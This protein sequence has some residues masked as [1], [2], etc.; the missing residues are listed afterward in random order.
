[1][2]ASIFR[3]KE[4]LTHNT[5][6]FYRAALAQVVTRYVVLIIIV[7]G[8]VIR[9]PLV[10]MPLTYSLGDTWRQTDTASIAH[11]FAG[12]DSSI[13]YPRIHWGGSGPGYVEAEFQ[14]Y[15]YITSL[16]YRV[17]GEQVALGRFVSLL[18]TLATF[19]IFHKLA[20]RL[21]SKASAHWALFAFAIMPLSIRY[22]TAFMPEATVLFF[23]VTALYCFHVWLDEQKLRLLLLAGGSTALAFL[24]KPT[25]INIGL[26]FA[27]LLVVRYR[28][29]FVLQ[30]QLW[31]F[32]AI[33][34]LP[35]V[36]WYLH[37]RNLFVLYGNTFGILSGGDSK[38][39]SLRYWLSPD[40]YASLFRIE[41]QWVFAGA[42]LLLFMIGL[43]LALR[44]RQPLLFLFG[45]IVV[46][47]YYLIVARYAGFDRG[48]QYHIYAIPFAA[49][50]IGAGLARLFEGVE[51]ALSLRKLAQ[52]RRVWAAALVV[53]LMIGWSANI[54]F[55]QLLLPTNANLRECGIRVSHF[56]PEDTRIIV[57]TTSLAV[58]DGIPNNYQEPD[59]F[60]YSHRNGWSLPADWH[61]PEQVEAYR[62]EGA[63][64]FVIY[65]S[66]VFVKNP[67]LAEYLATNAE[68]VGPGIEN[69]CGIFRFDENA[70]GQ[71]A[72]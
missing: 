15:T 49:L 51:G 68:Q 37:A 59:I 66:D 16:L 4:Q 65:S 22:S 45:V 23:Y 33:S 12:P 72:A 46:P 36:L 11:N 20:Q 2:L 42:G 24:V 6:T 10:F 1:M 55:N 60:F 9:L 40:F 70:S 62:R 52:A 32:A 26:I 48:V 71:L 39:G 3:A 27:L 8:L 31:L 69:G 56:V 35:G 5:R 50:G 38:F 61:T 64:Y 63:G 41:I 34:L 21:F 29:R 14:L 30:P 17:F 13:F 43:A 57:S 44:R 25:S 19:V 18:F 67:A 28:L 54:F 47:I 7:F 58:E 53:A